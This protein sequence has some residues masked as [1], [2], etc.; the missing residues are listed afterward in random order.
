MLREGIMG[1]FGRSPFGPTQNHMELVLRCVELL[2]PL[3]EAVCAGDQ[4]R[5]ETLAAEISDRENDAD[6]TKHEIRNH[7]PKARFLPID[8]RDLLEIV[9]LQDS[10]ADSLEETCHLLTLKPLTMPEALRTRSDNSPRKS[11]A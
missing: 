7:L 8:R 11:R 6:L 4:Q 1:R 2:E 5:V 9:H 10:I 3:S